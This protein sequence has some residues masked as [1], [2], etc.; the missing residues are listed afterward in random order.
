MVPAP[1]FAQRPITECPTNPSWALLAKPR[2][3]HDASSPRTLQCGPSAEPLIGPPSSTTPETSTVAACACGPSQ[4]APGP[5]PQ[6]TVTPWQLSRN[7][8]AGHA[9]ALP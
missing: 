2:N 6:P 4:P 5:T 7:A 1:R 9:G 3:T 8:P